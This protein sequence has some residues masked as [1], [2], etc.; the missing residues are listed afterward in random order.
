MIDLGSL[1]KQ[2]RKTTY[3]VLRHHLAIF[4]WRCS[5][6]ALLHLL[7]HLWGH[8]TPDWPVA[9]PLAHLTILPRRHL[10]VWPH[11]HGSSHGSVGTHLTH[12]GTHL[13]HGV[14]TLATVRPAVPHHGSV[15]ETL[16]RR[17]PVRVVGVSPSYITLGVVGVGT[18]WTTLLLLLLLLLLMHLH[19]LH[20][21]SLHLH[22]LVLVLLL[23]SHLTIWHHLKKRM[24]I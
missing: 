22:H 13:T 4:R 10:T 21:H 20:L 12:V 2:T 14:G 7:R 8:L 3:H 24:G 11:S 15:S 18:P 5:A 23:R 6:L 9:R 16:V 17:S 19:P 1:G